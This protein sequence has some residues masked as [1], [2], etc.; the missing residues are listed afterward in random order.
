MRES[1]LL[2][3]VLLLQGPPGISVPD[4]ESDRGNLQWVIGVFC[5]EVRSGEVDPTRFLSPRALRAHPDSFGFARREYQSMS[6]R[7]F[8]TYSV[9]FV[10][11]SHASVDA[12][13]VWSTKETEASYRATL[14]FEKVDGLSHSCHSH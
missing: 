3:V 10:D 7:D 13:V 8:S 4:R 9:R 1:W 12:L 5:V 2:L 14:F 11:E 6:I